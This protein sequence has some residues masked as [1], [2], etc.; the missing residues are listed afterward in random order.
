MPEAG[1]D[2]SG[3]EPD[4]ESLE[5]HY[6]VTLDFR[7]RLRP[8]TPEVCRECFFFQDENATADEQ[9]LRESVERQRRLLALLR[10]NERV[11][12]RYLLAVVAQQAA[13]VVF[14]GLAGVFGVAEDEDL[15][16]PLYAQMSEEDGRYFEGHAGE[17]LFWESAGPV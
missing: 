6:R 14:G 15:L 4:A 16:A 3:G 9:R 2:E 13:G 8:L 17:G 5:R 7:L 1:D 11:L 12:E 10:K